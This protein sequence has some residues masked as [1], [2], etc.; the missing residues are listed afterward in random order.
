MLV[1]VI[2]IYQTVNREGCYLMNAWWDGL[3]L[4]MKILYCISI[5]STLVL[6]LQ[7][8][9]SVAGFGDGPD[10][11]VSD[12]SGFDFETDTGADI[13]FDID[14]DAAASADAGTI[15]ETGLNNVVPNLNA[16]KLFTVQGILAFFSVF[17]WMSIVLISLGVPSAGAVII[18]IIAG[19]A[20]MYGVALLIKTLKGLAENGNVNFR[21]AI[22]ESA[23]VYIPVPAGGQGEGKVTITFQGKFMECDAITLEN[24]TLKTGQSVRVTDLRGDVLVVEQED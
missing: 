14:L 4:V 22:G 19:F 21:N 11:N 20:A 23:V 15:A 16:L 2:Y 24:R 6:I 5:P 10:I 18:G 1:N 9:F 13:G 17:S 12:T 7:T 8:I 3:D